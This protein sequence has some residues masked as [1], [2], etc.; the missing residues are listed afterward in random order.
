MA[1]QLF[2]I[3][4]AIDFSESWRTRLCMAFELYGVSVDRSQMIK[5]TEAL[6]DKLKFEVT[7]DTA[8]EQVNGD[9]IE[10]VVQTETMNV[11]DT[12]VADEDIIAEVE[13][14]IDYTDALFEQTEKVNAL[15][16]EVEQLT[17]VNEELLRQNDSSGEQLVLDLDAV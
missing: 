2:L 9:V 8:F 14:C 5:V 4:R 3:A 15:S 17:A 12:D 10:H 1:S 11:D 13:K 6:V 16:I 7:T